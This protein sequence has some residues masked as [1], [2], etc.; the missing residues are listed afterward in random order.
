MRFFGRCFDSSDPEPSHISTVVDNLFTIEIEQICER[1][2]GVGHAQPISVS[3][4]GLQASRPRL[5]ALAGRHSQR[6]RICD[7]DDAVA[8]VGSGAAV[9]HTKKNQIG[10]LNPLDTRAFLAEKQRK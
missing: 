1:A 6:R 2:V 3:D 9:P 8:V 4:M 7:A 10:N 5:I